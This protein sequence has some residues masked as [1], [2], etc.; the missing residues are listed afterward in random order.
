MKNNLINERDQRFVLYEMLDAE[1]IISARK[2]SREQLDMT[3]MAACDL[4][5]NEV[6]PA[7]QTGDKEGCRFEN[8]NVHVPQSFHRLKKLLDKGGWSSI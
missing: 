8:G 7:L 2:F 1:K 5:V 4:A 3:L 6:Y